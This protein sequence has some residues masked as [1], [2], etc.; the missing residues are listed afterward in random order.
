[1][2]ALDIT[3]HVDCF[4]SHIHALSERQLNHFVWIL[5]Y[6]CLQESPRRS[7]ALVRWTN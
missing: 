4:V 7:Y 6:V 1:M 5:F 2:T 3:S